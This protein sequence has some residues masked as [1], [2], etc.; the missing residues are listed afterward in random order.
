MMT[1]VFAISLLVAGAPPA[2]PATAAPAAATAPGKAAAKPRSDETVCKREP[3]LGSR[4]KQRICLT[5]G[6]WEARKADVRADIEKVQ[7]NQP[8]SK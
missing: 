7:T 3:V 2:Q 5:Q 6:E 8:I 4:M 1:L